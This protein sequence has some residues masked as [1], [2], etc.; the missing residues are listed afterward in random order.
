MGFTP[1]SKPE[2]GF[3]RANFCG[4]R[5]PGLPWLEHM[6]GNPN[7]GPTLCMDLDIFKYGPD[8]TWAQD[9]FFATKEASGYTHIQVSFGD[10][11]SQGWTIAETVKYALRWKARGGFIDVFVLGGGGPY[12]HWGDRDS[13]WAHNKDLVTPWIEAFIEAKAVDSLCVGWQLDGWHSGT[14]A[15]DNIIGMCELVR[16]R[17][18]ILACH[19]IHDACA[20]WDD[21]TAAKYGIDDRFS[22]YAF[23]H[24]RGYLNR[25]YLQYDVNAPISDYTPDGQP[26][27]GVQGTIR[28][29]ARAMQPGQLVTPYEYA[30]Q[31]QFNDPDKRSEESGDLRG[32][33]ALCAG[34]ELGG[35][36]NGARYPDGHAI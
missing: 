29:V 24:N 4:T 6:G 25:A 18:G 8:N 11:D 21:A 15:V 12:K 23:M 35:F 16:G 13:M 26:T 30:G 31:D 20:W 33:L 32:Y 9:L 28:D 14:S 27:S 5:V 2:A 17:I 3:M 22:F 10:A 7:T 36:G 34:V 1:P 19:W